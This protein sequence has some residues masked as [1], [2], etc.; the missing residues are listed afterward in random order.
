MISLTTIY[1]LDPEA[2]LPDYPEATFNFL[3]TNP[4]EK[5]NQK[6]TPAPYSTPSGYTRAEPHILLRNSLYEP[7]TEELT[8]ILAS[9]PKLYSPSGDNSILTCT[10]TYETSTE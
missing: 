7:T 5:P 4:P 3:Q 10:L 9:D 6:P 2:T 1:I 8:S